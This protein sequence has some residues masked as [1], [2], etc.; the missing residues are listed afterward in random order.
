ML[1]GTGRFDRRIQRQQTGLKRDF[2]NGP[3]DRPNIARA[4]PHLLNGQIM[5]ADP[6]LHGADIGAQFLQGAIRIAGTFQAG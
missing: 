2:L 6:L 1:Y 3:D 5:L 4:L